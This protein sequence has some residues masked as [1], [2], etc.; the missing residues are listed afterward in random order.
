MSQSTVAGFQP[1]P[2]AVTYVNGLSVEPGWRGEIATL[3]WPSI[4][5]SSKL[6]EPS[7][8]STSPLLGWIDDQRG[9]GRVARA[10]V[11]DVVAGRLLGERAAGRGRGWW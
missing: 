1:L 3:T 8:A 11:G 7:M 6:T 5:G 4:D 2:N 10:D 9:V